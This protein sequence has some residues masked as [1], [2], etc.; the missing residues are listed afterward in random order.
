[1]AAQ[2]WGGFS[3]NLV[4]TELGVLLGYL[5]RRVLG[6][7]DLALLGREPVTAGKLFF[8]EPNIQMVARTLQIPV[9]ELK[10]WLAL[11]ET[12]HAVQFEAFPWV[13]PHFNALIESYFS[14]LKGDIEELGKG[15][16]GLKLY[17]DRLRTQRDRSSW[18][19]ALMTPDQHR[20]YEQLQA[21]MC[22]IEGYSN[23]VMNATGAAVLPNFEEIHR[24][25][26]HR[27]RNRG[28][29]EELFA[30]FTGLDLKLEQ[31]RLGQAF[32][33]HVVETRG[34]EMAAALWSG[35]E[36]LPTLAEIR[37]PQS[38]IERMQQAPV[39]AGS[40]GGR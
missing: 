39:S 20:L 10:L 28:K 5:A 38:W 3:R 34:H 40:G 31:Y 11:H 21:L 7:Y 29:A 16:S 15:L 18:L 23:H 37:N 4:S 12:T 9:P 1:V 2:L 27:Q 13:R 36:N 22:V 33:D 6:Q 8:V 30:R 32:V 17:A 25:F 19:E 14:F 26:E 35:P 24:K